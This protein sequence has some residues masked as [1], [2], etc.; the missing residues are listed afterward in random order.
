MIKILFIVLL[1]L[2][3]AAC[4]SRL[5][6][7]DA[8]QGQIESD[9]Q[10]ASQAR[11]KPAQPDAVSQALLPPLTV[12]MPRAGKPVEPRFDL[13]VNNAPANQVFMAMVSGTR[14][15]MLVHPDIQ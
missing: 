11:V 8:V 15:S 5:F 6:K 4:E 10:R 1:A 13:T 2:S 14:Y 9:L 7:K 3:L 12:E